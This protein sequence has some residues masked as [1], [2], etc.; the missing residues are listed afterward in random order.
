MT[1]GRGW[2]VVLEGPEGSGKSTLAATLAERL[3]RA[4]HAPIVVR[5]P[6][7]TPA[8]EALRAAL[9]EPGLDW[10][11]EAE[12][13]FMVTAR[14]DLVR[15]VILPGLQ[16]GRVVL[17]DRFD[18]STRAYQGAGRG[19]AADRLEWLNR[20][21][22]GGLQPDLTLVLDLPPEAGLARQVAAGKAQDR[23]DRESAE[24]HRRI[25]EFYRSVR[26]PGILHVDASQPAADLAESAW[27]AVHTMLT[28]GGS[29]E[30]PVSPD[31]A[32]V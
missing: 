1:A 27:T 26:G 16:A 7:G 3:R 10:S 21:A 8:A 14:A 32:G 24:F 19:V 4:G 9:L 17:S 23:L 30:R 2:F 28:T 6:G 15:R 22:T 11:A 20:V 13:L 5:E 12:L 25:A 31:I 29:G 18:L